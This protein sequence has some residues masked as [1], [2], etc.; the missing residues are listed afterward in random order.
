MGCVYI[1][2]IDLFYPEKKGKFDVDFSF[3]I[4]KKE[5]D[6]GNYEMIFELLYMWLI[7]TW[8][9]KKERIYLRNKLIPKKIAQ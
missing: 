4:T 6:K 2:P 5:F 8:P 1:Y 3:W 7:H 9:F